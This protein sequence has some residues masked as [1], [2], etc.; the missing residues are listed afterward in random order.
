LTIALLTKYSLLHQIPL[1]FILELALI[2][3][4]PAPSALETTKLVFE[5]PPTA[6]FQKLIFIMR[7][8]AS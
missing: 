2:L 8:A 4:F 7:S 1:H 6:G 5:S 3:L